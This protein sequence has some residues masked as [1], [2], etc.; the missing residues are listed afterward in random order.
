MWKLSTNLLCSCGGSFPKK[1]NRN[2]VI[3]VRWDWVWHFGF[4][5]ETLHYKLDAWEWRCECFGNKKD[6]WKTLLGC[7]MA[8]VRSTAPLLVF[9]NFPVFLFCLFVCFVLS[10]LSSPNFLGKCSMQF[11]AVVQA[12]T[13]FLKTINKW[14]HSYTGTG[15]KS[16]KFVHPRLECKSE[17]MVNV[18][19]CTWLFNKVAIWGKS[20][21]NRKRHTICIC[22]H[23]AFLP[24]CLLIATTSVFHRCRGVFTRIRALR[25]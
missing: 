16:Y 9:K 2:Y 6:W 5:A 13:L 10:C 21:I 3:S 11:L 19:I 12:L 23:L 17:Y 24:V 18:C 25:I 8:N 22:K 4:W 1:R 7:N 15:E 14:E 20:W